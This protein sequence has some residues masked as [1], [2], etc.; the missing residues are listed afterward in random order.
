MTDLATLL[1]VWHIQLPFT[2]PGERVRARVFPRK[3]FRSRIAFTEANAWLR[4]LA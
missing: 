4:A 2:L 1:A 3:E